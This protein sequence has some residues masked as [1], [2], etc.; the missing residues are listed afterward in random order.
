MYIIYDLQFFSLQF[1]FSTAK[2]EKL[3]QQS[4]DIDTVYRE[5]YAVSEPTPLPFELPSNQLLLQV[6]Q[7]LTTQITTLEKQSK[8]ASGHVLLMIEWWKEYKENHEVTQIDTWRYVDQLYYNY[9]VCSID[10]HVQTG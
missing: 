2:F 7:K 1:A 9:T 10:R 3:K 5:F 8:D 4:Y 6:N